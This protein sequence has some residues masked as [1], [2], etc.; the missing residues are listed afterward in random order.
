MLLNSLMSLFLTNLLFITADINY[1]Q[2]PLQFI[3]DGRILNQQSRVPGKRHV[4]CGSR[5]RVWWLQKGQLWSLWKTVIQAAWKTR[6]QVYDLSTKIHARV[7]FS[8]MSTRRDCY[9][10]GTK[11]IITCWL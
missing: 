7:S 2:Y 6:P 9:M 3:H 10:S 11:D 8:S 1:V 4:L 5:S